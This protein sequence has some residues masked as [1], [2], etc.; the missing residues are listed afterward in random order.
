MENR[1]VMQHRNPVTSKGRK[2]PKGRHAETSRLDSDTS[3]AHVILP[4]SALCFLMGIDDAPKEQHLIWCTSSRCVASGLGTGG[5]VPSSNLWS[6]HPHDFCF[7]QMTS[8]GT[9]E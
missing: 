2:G 3:P 9:V 5:I 6:A 4:L 8:F 1:H 7:L